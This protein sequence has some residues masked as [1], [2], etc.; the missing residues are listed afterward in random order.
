VPDTTRHGSKQVILEDYLY[1]GYN[2][3]LTDLQA[4][5][6]IEQ[7]KKLEG[8]V[9][10]RR[11]LAGRY[12]AALAGHPWLEPP[13][14]PAWAEPN[15]QSYAVQLRAD[16]PVSRN[17]LMQQLLDQGIAT[18]RGIM[19]AHREP[20]YAGHANPVS[21]VHSEDTSARSLLLPLYPEMTESQQDAV[22]AALGCGPAT[23][24]AA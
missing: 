17:D 5:V 21:L 7:M 1:V 13:H 24:A 3:R 20:A 18:R 11:E 2:Y 22:L 4:A 16:A 14:V 12:N 9:R 6:G 23:R 10:R 8:I 19:L 15:F